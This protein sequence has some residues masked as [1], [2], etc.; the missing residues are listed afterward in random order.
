MHLVNRPA[1]YVAAA[2]VAGYVLLLKAEP[3]ASGPLT[4][5]EKLAACDGR[6]AQLELE[7]RTL[8]SALL[9]STSR[10]CRPPAVASESKQVSCNPRDE[11]GQRRN[12]NYKPQRV[13]SSPSSCSPPYEFDQQGNKHYKPQCLDA[14]PSPCTPP[15]RFDSEG[16]KVYKAG[17]I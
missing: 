9:K 6:V 3:A 11:A 10:E 12:K 16:L 8:R 1:V 17:C 4:Q 13:D 14:P 2:L 5:S 7:V 15:Y